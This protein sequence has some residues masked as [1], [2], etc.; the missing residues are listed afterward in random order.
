MGRL[1]KGHFKLEIKELRP[2]LNSQNKNP[3][4]F[5]ARYKARVIKTDDVSINPDDIVS[6]RMWHYDKAEDYFNMIGNFDGDVNDIQSDVG[7]EIDI[8]RSDRP[9]ITYINPFG[10]L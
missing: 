9:P 1:L 3:D 5:T 7:E 10:P 2:P 6:V 4:E 8:S